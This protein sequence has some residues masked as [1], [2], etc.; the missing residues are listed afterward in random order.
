MTFEEA[1]S[2][3]KNGKCITNK[4]YGGN[5]LLKTEHMYCFRSNEIISDDWVVGGDQEFPKNVV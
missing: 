5:F 2:E 1:I 4:Y 3:M